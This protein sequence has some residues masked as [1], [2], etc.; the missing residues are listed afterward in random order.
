LAKLCEFPKSQEWKLLYRASIDG[1]LS[2]DF[3]S[4]CDRIENTLTVIKSE[5]G[6]VFGGYTNKAWTPGVSELQIYNTDPNAFIFSLI[7]EE[8]KSFKVF[9]PDGGKHAILCHRNWGPTFGNGWSD[10]YIADNSNTNNTSVCNLGNTYKH[11]DYPVGTEKAKNIL[12]GSYG[13]KTTEI[14]INTKIN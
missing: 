14:E 10:I 2:K 1:F 7:N 6:N 5:S 13:F 8:S 11:P 9:C 12:A 4:K 3:H